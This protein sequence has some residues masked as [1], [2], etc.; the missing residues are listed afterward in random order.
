VV[1][2]NLSQTIAR[3]ICVACTR[4]YSGAI[5][6]CPH[7]G[8]ALVPIAEDL[9]L[10][11]KLADRYLIQS[12]VGHGG[13]GVVYKARHELMERTVAIKMLQLSMTTDT[14]NVQRFQHEGKAA[15]RLN[16]PHVIT[17]YD[18]GISPTGQPYLVMDYL[19]GV[20]LSGIIKN[21]GQIGVERGLRIFKQVC[22]ALEHAHQQRIIHRDLKP[23][24][25]ML[26]THEEEKDFVKVVDF[27]VAKIMPWGGEDVQ[28]LTQTGEVCGSPVYMSP[29]QCLGQKLDQRSDIYSMGIVMYESLTGQLPHLGKTMVETMAKHLNDK[30]KPF[31]EIRPDLYIPERLEAVVFKALEKDPNIRPQSMEQLREE[32]EFSIPRPERSATLRLVDTSTQAQPQPAGTSQK[33]R[34]AIA[35]AA[36]AVLFFSILLGLHL[37]SDKRNEQ[38]QNTTVTPKT[39][40]AAA[41]GTTFNT[42][43]STTASPA[44][45][46]NTV[47]KPERVIE[48]GK[49]PDIN[50]AVINTAPPIITK[51]A[52]AQPTQATKPIAIKRASV[53][54]ASTN[55]KPANS[56]QASKQSSGGKPKD[57]A[58]LGNSRSYTKSQPAD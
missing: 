54:K 46:T 56:G 4:V 35:V 3:K 8:S 43:P 5:Q 11:T 38:A 15:S 58:W 32:L 42:T 12:L 39:K 19:E 28:R 52:L 40:E 18:Y 17:L 33:S 24:N 23:S 20:S 48:S 14:Q 30:P 7:D 44:N 50:T 21:D 57:W 13:M 47:P 9:L 51:P 41:T 6:A 45:I 27:G 25:I 31:N 36:V 34:I 49:I 22:E 16:H 29:E 53:R 2:E 26:V 1:A 55:S 10:G 37:T